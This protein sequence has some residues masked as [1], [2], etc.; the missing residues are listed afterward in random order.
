MPCFTF[1]DAEEA[2]FGAKTSSVSWS[3]C[4]WRPG[5][6]LTHYPRG[7]M[8]GQWHS[9][10]PKQLLFCSNFTLSYSGNGSL[11]GGRQGY[12]TLQF[13][14][15]WVSVVQQTLCRAH[16]AS[17]LGQ[18]NTMIQGQQALRG[19]A[20][21][22]WLLRE[23]QLWRLL[24]SFQKQKILQKQWKST[25]L[26]KN[27]IK[28]ETQKLIL[29][30]FLYFTEQFALKYLLLKKKEKNSY[31]SIFNLLFNLLFSVPLILVISANRHS[32]CSI[33][34]FFIQFLFPTPSD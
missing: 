11:L 27:P 1:P 3:S 16:S 25:L 17:S 33:H 6:A 2:A 14:I 32:L 22:L 20:K 21:K 29:K 4:S 26:E 8:R 10:L 7:L 12:G 9:G 19:E 18:C 31:L 28:P 23:S 13:F 34:I 5:S 30:G 24:L 15:P